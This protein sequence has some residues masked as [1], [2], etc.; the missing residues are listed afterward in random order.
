MTRVFFVLGT[1][2]ITWGC[3]IEDSNLEDLE[4][5]F[6]ADV[7]W[8]DEW[9]DQN[10]ID[11]VQD[12]SGLRYL[13]HEQGTGAAAHP[14]TSEI[15][16]NYQGRLMTDGSIFDEGEGVSF[17]IRNLIL[18]WRIGIPLI[19]E[20][21]SITLYIPSG[22]AYGRNGTTGIPPNANIVFDVDLIKVE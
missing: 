13:I 10:G 9:L 14:D 18:G 22:Y 7:Q 11:A 16:I 19:Q 17:P 1:L 15:T 8:I 20:G 4:A 6:N 21:G 12:S 2:F 5:Q 3:A